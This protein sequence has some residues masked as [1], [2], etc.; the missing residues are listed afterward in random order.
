MTAIMMAVLTVLGLLGSL[1][2][3]HTV[4]RENVTASSQGVVFAVDVSANMAGAPLAGEQAAVRALLAKLDKATPV[5]LV[6]FG[7][8]VQIAQR[9]TTQKA[10][11]EAALKLLRVEGGTALYDG[12]LTAVDVAGRLSTSQR[13]VVLLSGNGEQSRQSLSKANAAL[14]LAQSRGVAVY[15]LRWGSRADETYLQQ[16]AAGT[17]AVSYA[18]SDKA[19]QTTVA[20]ITGNSALQ[21]AS[22]D[23]QVVAVKLAGATQTPRLLTAGTPP[24]QETVNMVLAI[25]VSNAMSGAPLRTAQAA[26]RQFV[27]QTADNTPMALVTFGSQAKLVQT[28]TIDKAVMTAAINGLRAGNGATALYDGTQ[29]AVTTAASSAASDHVV[30]LLSGST[31]QGRQSKATRQSVLTSVKARDVIVYSL[32][33]S[34]KADHP[35][36]QALA[37]TSLGTSLDRPTDAQLVSFY[38]TIC[39]QA[40]TATSQ[41]A[42]PASNGD[43]NTLAVSDLTNPVA[44]A[45]AGTTTVQSVGAPDIPPL[46]G[47]IANLNLPVPSAVDSA[48][49]AQTVGSIN[50]QTDANGSTL[51]TTTNARTTNTVSASAVDTAAAALTGNDTNATRDAAA[52]SEA[53]LQPHGNIVPIQVDVPADSHIS[54]AELSVNGYRLASF[55]QAPYTYDFD[56]SALRPGQYA[57]TFSVTS[58]QGVT[59]SGS[60][61][62]QVTVPTPNAVRLPNL[63]GVDAAGQGKTASNTGSTDVKAADAVAVNNSNGAI[64]GSA[65]PGTATILTPAQRVLL[66]DGKAQALH[67]NF[68][69][70]Q[71]LS[72]VSASAVSAAKPTLLDIL[73]R[74][75]TLLPLPVREALSAQHPTFW[76]LVILLMTLIF[77]PQGLFTLYWM[78][79]TWNNPEVAERYRSPREFYAPE[80][81]FTALLPARHEAGVIRDTIRAVDRINYPDY[82][83]EILILVR[84]EDDDETIRAAQ[85]TIE[86][87]GKSNIRLITFTTGPKNKPNGLNRGLAAASNNVVCVFD[88]EDEP[89]PDLYNVI[90]TVMMR[91]GADVVQ[92]GVQLMNFASN[93]FSALN[94]MEYYFW[95][96]SGLHAFTRA[97]KVTPLGGNTVFFKKHWLQRI[98]GWDEHCLTEDADVGLRLSLLGA[99][100]QIVYDEAHVTQEETPATAESFIKQRT[101]WCQGF[102]EIFFKGDWFKLPSV[103]QKLTALYILL[104]SLLQAGIVLY[105]PIGLYVALTQHISLIVALLSYVPIFL[106]L[107]QLVITLVGL[108]EFAEAYDKRLPFGFRFKVAL[109]YYPYQLMLAL[110]SLRAIQHFLARKTAWEKTAHA[111]LHRQAQAAT[112]QSF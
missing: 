29:L 110:A 112:Q 43:T 95:F 82:L 47:S 38:T 34:A 63:G 6:T 74:P 33:V 37:S 83:K 100:I 97:L 68:S 78:M 12:A 75:L 99:K 28:Y 86:E 13:T 69:V 32:S 61:D 56:T 64:Q 24:G 46:D 17:Q 10:Y 84:D 9:A 102:Y 49:K 109:V 4:V 57:L 91:D 80:H 44:V 25:D 5:A 21:V 26:A 81:S 73:G 3:P 92:S 2:G 15:S 19:I 30:L 62:F 65:V 93:W 59:S 7:S 79:Y 77:L 39:G 8:H 88:A 76:A 18:L 48:I 87:L 107:L 42:L 27:A 52:A 36:L 1:F 105:L 103:G 31:E 55:A 104:N 66:V 51:S 89:H 23:S 35:F 14:V 54:T 20:R 45:E 106:L 71:G 60:L 58:D 98:N 72:L 70:E 96:K 111:N 94:C 67:L 16:L 22:A 108:R 101:R 53:A 85:Q 50:A 40:T 90:N 11:V 41:V